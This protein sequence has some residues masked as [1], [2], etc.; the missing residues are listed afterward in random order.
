M[1][2]KKKMKKNI[3][4]LKLIYY[5]SYFLCHNYRLQKIENYN[6]LFAKSFQ[7]L[8]FNILKRYFYSYQLG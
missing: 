3:K 7:L 4:N 8:F 2:N 6:T 1:R 5:I